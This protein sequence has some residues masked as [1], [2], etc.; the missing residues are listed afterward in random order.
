MAE[1][2]G[3]IN[4]NA[5]NSIDIK[6]DCVDNLNDKYT[7]ETYG[8][9]VDKDSSVSLTTNSEDINILNNISEKGDGLNANNGIVSEGKVTL[10]SGNDINIYTYSGGSSADD[11]VAIENNGV[12]TLYADSNLN[13]ISENIGDNTNTH[14]NRGIYTNNDSM[15]DADINGSVEITSNG[16][17]AIGIQSD[18]SG[19]SIE[20]NAGEGIVVNAI[21]HGA[22]S[23]TG[24]SM[25]VDS[26]GVW[27]SGNGTIK[28]DTEGQIS[29]T[30][31]NDNPS[32][33]PF[34]VWLLAL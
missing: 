12:M 13:I 28:L 2:A 33:D 24:G 8:I 23:P 4:I 21:G 29:I 31:S 14:I 34:L 3:N 6:V 30:A 16:A 27:N 22:I 18:F 11:R 10:D 32:T 9:Y 25:E 26:Y 7:T 15:F 1:T 5:N 20:I 19:G 17:S